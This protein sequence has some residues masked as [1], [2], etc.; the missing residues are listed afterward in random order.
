MKAKVIK[1]SLD[2]ASFAQLKQWMDEATFQMKLAL[3]CLILSIAMATMALLVLL[4]ASNDFWGYWGFMALSWA[5][6]GA[7]FM[8]RHHARKLWSGKIEPLFLKATGKTFDDVE[9]EMLE[10]ND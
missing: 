1:G 9:N 8:Y 4:I 5:M 3:A 6:W 7:S 2:E 10:E